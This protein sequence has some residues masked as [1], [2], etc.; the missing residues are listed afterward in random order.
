VL[1][2]L[3]LEGQVRQIASPDTDHE[4]ATLEAARLGRRVRASRRL[5]DD[6]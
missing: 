3:G 4:G 6:F 1:W 5:S 2:A